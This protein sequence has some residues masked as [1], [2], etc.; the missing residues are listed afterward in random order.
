MLANFQLYFIHYFWAGAALW[1]VYAF[2][3]D[4]H[5]KKDLQLQESESIA[6]RY[7]EAKR[8]GLIK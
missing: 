3:L 6:H 5:K 1:T 7:V 8:R 2:Y 4:F